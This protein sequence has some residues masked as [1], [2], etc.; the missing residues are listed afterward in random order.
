MSV[1]ACAPIVLLA[2]VKVDAVLPSAADTESFLEHTLNLFRVD[3][4]CLLQGG[5][6]VE[7]TAVSPL[8][9]SLEKVRA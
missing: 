5:V 1:F 2:A 4:S 6:M 7:T 3:E 8:A 9:F